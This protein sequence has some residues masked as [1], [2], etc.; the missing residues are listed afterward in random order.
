MGSRVELFEQI[1]RDHQRDGLSIHEL[2][3]RHGVHRRTVRRALESPFPPARKTPVRR[4]PKLDPPKPLIDAMLRADLDAPRKQRHT[5]RRV[6][7]RLVDEHGYAELTYPSVRD[8]VARRRAEIRAEAGR[9]AEQA[10]VPQTHPPGAEAEVDFADVWVHLA[11]VLTRCFL[12]TLRLS[13]SGKAVHRVFASQGQ[14]AFIEGHLHAFAILGGVPLDKI[15][16]DNL[17]SAVKRVLFGRNRVESDQWVAFRSWA[18][19]DAFY[20]QPGVGGA[21]EKGGVEGEG[22]RFRRTHLVPVPKVATLAELNAYLDAC[23]RK[24]DHRRIVNRPTTVGMDFAAEAPLLRPL[25]A[26]PFQAGLSLTPRVDRYGRIMVRQCH[27]SVPVRYIGR[28]VRA[29]LGASELVV[30]DGRLEIARH[31]GRCAKARRP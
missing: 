16:Y 12:F 9:A 24:D 22:G 15:R 30:F 27:Y 26:E 4:A 25:P 7:A 8:Y 31:T 6:L 17:K 2:S 13:H 11:G 20:C 29:R 23:D 21:H 5:A 1:R 10:F 19:F 28:R 14:E 18:G 3:R